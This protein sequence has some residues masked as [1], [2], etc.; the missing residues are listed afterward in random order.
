MS[1]LKQA[2][3]ASLKPHEPTM[4]VD[5]AR[6]SIQEAMGLKDAI[7]EAN[8]ICQKL[9][10]LQAHSKG[11]SGNML[12]Y[13]ANEIL[14]ELPE[15]QLVIPG[16][17]SAD[18]LGYE[19]AMEGI[20]ETITKLKDWIKKQSVAMMK[21]MK[22]AF[23][24][25]GDIFRSNNTI[26]KNLITE[27]GKDGTELKE[28]KVSTGG[29]AKF[30]QVKGKAISIPEGM[31][32]IDKSPAVTGLTEAAP[33]MMKAIKSAAFDDKSTAD[34]LVEVYE[35]LVKAFDYKPADKSDWI[36]AKADEKIM[37][38][39]L[40]LPGGFAM[41]YVVKNYP[42][43]SSVV[44]Y[45]TSITH[46]FDDKKSDEVKAMGE[47]DVLSKEDMIKAL[48]SIIEA[49]ENGDGALNDVMDGYYAVYDAYDKVITQE[50]LSTDWVS[51]AAVKAMLAIFELLDSSLISFYYYRTDVID[52]YVSTLKAMV[53]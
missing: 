2:I 3:M 13:A 30:F 21:A 20:S 12:Q 47:I 7:T 15:L 34:E 52:K 25:F 35:I 22:K 50:Q 18:D 49:T 16:M 8:T 17:E 37:V 29:G 40:G 51:S 11:A 31:D 45:A 6:A 32:I 39:D 48:E 46:K 26:A 41:G 4:S 24:G 36:K 33:A 5:E 28:G 19:V 38:S 1:L 23:K 44:P 9:E 53:K 42:I 10:E 27:L 14:T 43:G